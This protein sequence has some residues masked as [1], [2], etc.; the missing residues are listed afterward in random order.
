[1]S[2]FVIFNISGGIGKCVAATAV[3][4][5]I[6]KQYPDYDLIVVSGYPDVF[7]NNSNVKKSFAFGQ[8]SYFYTDYI[9]N[10][11]VKIFFHDPYHTT[12]YVKRSKH[13]IEI[14][15]NL[16]GVKYNG[17]LPQIFMTQREIDYFHRQVNVQKP[18]LLMQTNG[19]GDPNKK[20]S[21]A[22]DLPVSVVMPIIEHFKN[23]Y[24]IV[25]VR[26]EDQQEY[27]N[28]IRLTA[29]FRQVVATS[30]LS[31][32]R[33]VMDSF[34][35]HALAALNLPAVACWVVNSPE[36]FGYDMHTH[37]VHNPF[38]REP[39]LRSAY[40]EQ[41]N[42]GGDELEFPYNDESEI[43]NVTRIIDALEK[44]ESAPIMPPKKNDGK[45]ILPI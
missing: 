22:R 30:M 40:I 35:Q 28:T 27:P 42:I 38:T 8:T 12:D 7:I 14:W 26:R 16:Y 39:E 19:G 34:L 24:D 23:D 4:A 9:H 10:K 13:L 43:F 36:V 29:S 3:C 18:I 25:H 32:K 17:E 21:W 41:F 2:K 11:D 20:Y 5:A 44:S 1:M 33:L 37:I 6:K 45:I 15:C 31:Q